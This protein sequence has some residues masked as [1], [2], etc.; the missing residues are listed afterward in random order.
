[1]YFNYSTLNCQHENF[2]FVFI[3]YTSCNYVFNAVIYL[4]EIMNLKINELA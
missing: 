2:T 3:M 4:Y 1:M